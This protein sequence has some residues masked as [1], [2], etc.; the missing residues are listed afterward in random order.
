[1]DKRRHDDQLPREQPRPS[2]DEAEKAVREIVE[3]EREGGEVNTGAEA[4]QKGEIE[5]PSGQ[6]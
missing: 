5:K 3:Q 4:D 1:M 2:G 6:H